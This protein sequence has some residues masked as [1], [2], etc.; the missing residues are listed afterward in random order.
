MSYPP[1]FQAAPPGGGSRNLKIIIGILAGVGILAVITM[2]LFFGSK[3]TPII[4]VDIPPGWEEA[5]EETRSDFEKASEM[6]DEDVAI[7][8]LFTDGSLTNV[9]AVAHGT[10]YILDKPESEESEEV[11]DFFMRHEQE[12][13]DIFVATYEEIGGSVE[14][15]TYTIEEIACGLAALHMSVSIRGAGAQMVQDFLFFFKDDTSFFALV[16]TM[17]SQ[18]NQE[19]VDFLKENISFE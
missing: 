15:T 11:E 1:G 18:D 17:G 7:D 14:M 19:E 16:S 2:F 5:D 3:K 4:K 9:I 6:G 10:A 13:E 8:Y 12:L